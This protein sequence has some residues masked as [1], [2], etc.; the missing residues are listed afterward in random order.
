MIPSTK[1]FLFGGLLAAAFLPVHAADATHWK[2]S[3]GPGPAPAGSVAVDPHEVYSAA[4]GYGF[5]PGS[6]PLAVA[7]PPGSG[8]VTG[9]QPFYFSVA[10]PEGEYQVTVALGDPT[11]PALTTV[12]AELRRLELLH[13]RTAAGELATR[14][15]TVALRRP[16]FPGGKVR[17]KPREKSTEVWDWDDK[18]TLEFCDQRPCVASVEIVPVTDRPTLYLVGD[19]T[20]TDQPREPHNSWGQMITSFFGP[21]IV[22]SSHAESGESA[23]DFIS[24]NRWAK[25]MSLIKPGDFV[26][27]QFGHNDQHDRGPNPGAYASYSTFLHRYVAETRAHGATL[28]LVTPMNRLAFDGDTVTNTLGDFPDAMRKVAKDDGVAL[29]D[30]NAMSKVLYEALGPKG[31]PAIFAPTPRGPDTTHQGDYG[32]Y[33][34][35]KCVVRGIRLGVPELAKYLAPDAPQFDPAHPDPVAAF[36]VP[37]EKLTTTERPYGN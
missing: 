18:L 19:S 13:V 16:E 9:S 30:L 23:R 4:K 17:L 34:L 27:I 3:F 11:A 12:K 31:A 28:V 20:M 24:E 36:D 33:E 25:L 6:T 15:F 29:V 35:S 32:S 22:V 7:R 26:I 2:F 1:S 21:D 14:T 8:F 10:L 37:K 5:E